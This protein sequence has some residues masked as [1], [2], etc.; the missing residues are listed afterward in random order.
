MRNLIGISGKIGSGKDEVFRIIQK[1]TNNSFENRKFADQLKDTVCM[2][3]GCTREQLEDRGFKEK[4][5]GDEWNKYRIIT[6]GLPN[7]YVNTLE[8]AENNVRH[9]NQRFVEVKMTP[10][11]MLQLLG[12][13]AGR[14]IIHPNIWVNALF[15]NYKPVKVTEKRTDTLNL[16]SYKKPK[17]I[18]TDC[19]FSNEAQAIQDRNGIVIRLNRG[20]GNTGSHASETGL[21]NFDD[22]DYIVD[23]NGTINDLESKIERILKLEG[24][25]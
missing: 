17:W 23:N 8:K 24:I 11:L 3:I 15:S 12:T 19:R 14:E 7:Y 2:W 18:I 6:K 22:F 10:R 16:K 20:D 5:L 13:E 9:S 25:L 1:L 4:E 21:D